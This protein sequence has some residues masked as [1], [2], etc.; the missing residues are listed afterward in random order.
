MASK[1][2]MTDERPLI[3]KLVGT[4]P[5]E[6]QAYWGRCTYLGRFF[7]AQTD[8]VGVFLREAGSNR[9]RLAFR[10]VVSEPSVDNEHGFRFQLA[11]DKNRLHKIG[12]TP[13]FLAG[14]PLMVWLPFVDAVKVLPIEGPPKLGF[15]ICYRSLFHPE[16][17][18]A[19][20]SFFFLRRL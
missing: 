1:P 10:F 6:E 5:A 11:D 4:L 13:S 15:N 19:P 20:D 8:Q 14:L 12:H 2:L 9:T 18:E 3:E 17:W 16:V 7:F